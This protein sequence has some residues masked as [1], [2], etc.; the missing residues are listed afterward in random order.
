[1]PIIVPHQP[2]VSMPGLV[3]L[4]AGRSERGKW[5][6]ETIE[7]NRQ[8]NQSSQFHLFGLQKH[9]NIGMATTQPTLRSQTRTMRSMAATQ[10]PGGGFEP[11]GASAAGDGRAAGFV[12]QL[13]AEAAPAKNWPTC[14]PVP[15]RGTISGRRGIGTCC[16]KF[17]ASG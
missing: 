12:R 3:A 1:M 6:A 8:S 4:A 15:G 5:T 2:V 10:R 11:A 14:L 9:R 17:F 13:S 16:P 7:Q